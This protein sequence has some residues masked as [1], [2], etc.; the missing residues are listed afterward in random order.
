MGAN[1]SEASLAHR[2]V[3]QLED[4]DEERDLDVAPPEMCAHDMCAGQRAAA[5]T[6]TSACATR[7]RQSP[8][9]ACARSSNDKHHKRMRDACTSVTWASMRP[10]LK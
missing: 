1:P 6:I 4:D 7:A 10:K 9:R 8:G 2:V 3:V 5:R